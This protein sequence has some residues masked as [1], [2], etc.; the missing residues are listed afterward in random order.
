MNILL[1][2]YFRFKF[3]IE[4]FLDPIQ[5]LNEFSKRIAQ[6]Y[7]TA[8]T[9]SHLHGKWQKSPFYQGSGLQTR[10]CS[11][12]CTAIEYKPTGLASNSWWYGSTGWPQCIIAEVALTG[13]GKQWNMKFS[14][15][16]KTLL[17]FCATILLPFSATAQKPGFAS[18]TSYLAISKVEFVP[19]FLIY[20]AQSQIEF[21]P[22]VRLFVFNLIQNIVKYP[23][24]SIKLSWTA[25]NKFVLKRR[26]TP[27]KLCHH[28]VHRG[29]SGFWQDMGRETPPWKTCK[30][31]QPACPSCGTTWWP[32]GRMAGLGWTRSKRRLSENGGGERPGKETTSWPVQAT[33]STGC[34]EDDLETGWLNWGLTL[35][36]K[37]IEPGCRVAASKEPEQV[38]NLS[39]T[40]S[41]A[42]PGPPMDTMPLRRRRCSDTLIS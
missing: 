27:A 16:I 34:L 2:E 4:S 30:R 33:W 28:T 1:N 31:W 20:G 21:S 7:T 37:T 13:H 14:V 9:R 18:K 42:F 35:T 19:Y 25:K 8:N 15:K 36:L 32:P 17:L 5:R 26:W 11:P 23:T 29:W 12:S 41:V 22:L 3:W 38:L 6:G 24:R 10:F 39:L 40:A